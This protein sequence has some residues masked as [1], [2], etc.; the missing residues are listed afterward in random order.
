MVLR[1]RKPTNVQETVQNVVQ[2]LDAFVKVEEHYVEQSLLG[3]VGMIPKFL[4]SLPK[5]L[6]FFFP[7]NI[8]TLFLSIN[9]FFSLHCDLDSGHIFDI[10]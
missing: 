6:S 1:H 2:E 3:A 7:V 4:L 5:E 10:H 9:Y 8:L